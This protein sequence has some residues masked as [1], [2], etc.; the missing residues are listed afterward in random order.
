MG[1][2]IKEVFPKMDELIYGEN[3]RIRN[4]RGLLVL[5]KTLIETK[6]YLISGNDLLIKE[7]N[8]DELL[9][10]GEV[11][12]IKVKGERRGKNKGSTC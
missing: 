2:R 3:L 4:Y 7:L 11:T 9:I 6:R 1:L 10:T 8:K 5:D 12:N